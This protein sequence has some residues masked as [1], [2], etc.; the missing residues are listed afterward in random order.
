MLYYYGGVFADLDVES[1]RPLDG[2]LSKYPCII[3]QEPS[4]H[5]AFLYEGELTFIPMPGFMA[6]RPRHPFFKHV[7]DLLADYAK[8]FPL[9]VHQ[10]TGPK[11]LKDALDIYLTTYNKT[12]DEYIYL[13]PPK[14]FLPTYDPLHEH[15]FKLTC[16]KLY[17]KLLPYKQ[18][19][20]DQLKAE[21]FTNKPEGLPYTDHHWVHT[22]SSHFKSNGTIVVR[23]VLAIAT[24]V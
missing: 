6:C 4:A 19:V 3:A 14:W 23:Q 8:D 5:R 11:F 16:T 2:I 24:V 13:A 1:L 17:H 9:D 21:N 15:G 18:H 12:A 22:V 10:S 20:C 7:I